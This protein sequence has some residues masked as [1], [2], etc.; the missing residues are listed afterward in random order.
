VSSEEIKKQSMLFS[1]LD[2]NFPM[3]PPVW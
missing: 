2:K 1:E 3:P